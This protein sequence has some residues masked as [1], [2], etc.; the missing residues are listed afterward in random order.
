MDIPWAL[1]FSPIRGMNILY[2]AKKAE[3]EKNK[4]TKFTVTITINKEDKQ[5]SETYFGLAENYWVAISKIYEYII[6]KSDINNENTKFRM[7][8]RI[9]FLLGNR[10]HYVMQCD[11]FKEGFFKTTFVVILANVEEA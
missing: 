6:N 9:R 8:D 5:F 1:V 7:A 10:N 3:K 2:S 4:M 11:R